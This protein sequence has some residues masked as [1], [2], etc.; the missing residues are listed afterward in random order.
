M[1]V[2]LLLIVAMRVTN[3]ITGSTE[4]KID[5]MIFNDPARCIRNAN[6]NERLFKEEYKYTTVRAECIERKVVR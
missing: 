1:T 2:Y 3:P 4:T 5:T 6:Y